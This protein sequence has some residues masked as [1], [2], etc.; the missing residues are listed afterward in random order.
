MTRV[1]TSAH[2]LLRSFRRLA[3]IASTLIVGAATATA[4]EAQPPAEDIPN[5]RHPT[6]KP[7]GPR[8][9]PTGKPFGRQ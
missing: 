1:P 8:R 5:E 6:G 3:L 7:F 9:R 2:A 4:A